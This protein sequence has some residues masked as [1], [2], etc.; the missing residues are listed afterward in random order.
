MV[1]FPHPPHT[2]ASPG[3]PRSRSPRCRYPAGAAWRDPSL[4]LRPGVC[5]LHPASATT[6]C[7]V[8]PSRAGGQWWGTGRRS[9]GARH[10]GGSPLLRPPLCTF[11]HKPESHSETEA[12]HVEP[13]LADEDESLAIAE[14][15]GISIAASGTDPDLL[16]CGQCQMN[17]PLGDILVFIEHKRKQCNGTGGACYEKSMD[18]SSPPPSSRAELRK[19]SEPVE[20]GIQ[21]TPDEE[22]RLL[23]PTKGICPKQENIAG[24]SRPANLPGAPIAASSH[25]HTSV[26]TSPL[27]AL[28][29]LPP[30]L[31]LPCCGAR[32]VSVGG[33]QT[34]IQTETSGTFGCHCQLS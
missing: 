30:C 26:I 8:L 12:D 9:G 5:G 25:P 11:V 14:P 21:V 17:F 27:R 28:A 19:V 4:R 13:A 22:D 33:T 18:K 1:I 3:S 7:V 20:I 29:S 32:A 24:P 2:A 31:S 34:E 10:G 23:T 6:R 16:T 15:G